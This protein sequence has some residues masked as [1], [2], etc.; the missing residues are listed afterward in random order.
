M[1]FVPINAI[2]PGMINARPIYGR[3]QEMLL[4]EGIPFNDQMIKHILDL[5]YNGI[6][7]DYDRDSDIPFVEVID[8]QLRIEAV[9]KIKN[10]FLTAEKQPSTQ[11]I[12]HQKKD[13]GDL[14]DKLI[15]DIIKNKHLMINMIDLKVF[16]DYTFYHSVNVAV[17]AM[18]LGVAK[19]LARSQLYKL[20]LSALLH[21]IGKI[22][23]SKSILDKPDRLT[24]EEFEIMKGHSEEGY[25]YLKNIYDVPVPIYMAV[26]FHHEQYNG[27]GYPSGLTKNDIPLFSK[28]IMIADVFDALTSD[29]VYRKGLSPSEAVEYI[30]GNSGQMFDPEVVDIFLKKVAPYPVGSA[31]QLSDNRV[32]IVT[33]NFEDFGLRPTLKIIKENGSFVESAYPVDL[34]SMDTLDVTVIGISQDPELYDIHISSPS[35]S[36]G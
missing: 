26:K 10:A 32:G 12:L 11:E 13:I 25:S 30:M 5:G 29:R 4:R 15:D 22:M 28:L 6:Y 18:V 8:N 2:R 3:N 14:L 7:I 16:D 35:Y 27:S 19:N 20:G 17:I 1:R 23:I 34:R 33:D 24:P 36:Q 9:S 31:I 21:D